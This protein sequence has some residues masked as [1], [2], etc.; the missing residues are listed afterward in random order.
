VTLPR[1]TI[2]GGLPFAR[3]DIRRRRVSLMSV[4]SGARVSPRSSYARTG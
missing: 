2:S 3:T 4:P 1:A